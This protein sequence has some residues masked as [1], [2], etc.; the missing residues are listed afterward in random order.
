MLPGKPL[1]RGL[2]LAHWFQRASVHCGGASIGVGVCGEIVH[3]T[4]DQ[5][6]G[7]GYHFQSDLLTPV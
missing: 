5:E 3:I 6:P 7:V 1:K 2:I 4:A